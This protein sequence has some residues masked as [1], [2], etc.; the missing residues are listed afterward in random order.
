MGMFDY[1]ICHYP[2]P[3]IPPPWATT[4]HQ[5]QSK[6]LECG[7][8]LYKI[9]DDGTLWLEEYDVEDQS[10]KA[11]WKADHPG[12]PLPKELADNPLSGLIGCMS[13]VNQRWV[14]Q[15]FDGVIEFYDS[16]A[17]AGAYGM[18]F[19]PDGADHESVTYEATFAGG[20]VTKIVETERSC[21]PS[22]S[23]DIYHQLDSM[24]QEDGP[25]I[26]MSEPEVGAEMYV[27]W[28]SIDRNREGYPARLIV[29]TKR[30][31]AFTVKHDRIETIAPSQ[32][33]N[34]LFHSEADAKAQRGWEYKL[35]DKKSEYCN[36]LIKAKTEPLQI[37][38]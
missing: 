21:E 6:S 15:D 20:V 34:C 2:L 10:D 29:K 13:R 25:S 31:W 3:T 7:M 1:V 19:T 22:L 38:R 27:L 35:W 26:D 24:F 17:C 36:D 37:S 8:D 18:T 5:Y 33:G 23:S 9:R 16:N 32:L 4:D 30:D 28:G 11:K 14:Q 12:E